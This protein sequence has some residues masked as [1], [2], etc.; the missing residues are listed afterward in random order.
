L[1]NWDIVKYI[2]EYAEIK[3]HHLSKNVTF[4]LVT[5]LTLM[6]DEKLDYILAHNIHISTSLD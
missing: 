5:N 1:V 2:T 3:A 6:D 4:A